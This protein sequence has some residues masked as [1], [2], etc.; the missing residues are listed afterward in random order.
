MKKTLL[1]IFIS[2]LTIA[3]EPWKITAWDVSQEQATRLAAGMFAYQSVPMAAE[4][5]WEGAA[6]DAKIYVSNGG[7]MAEFDIQNNQL[8]TSAGT[9]PLPENNGKIRVEIKEMDTTV[10]AGER[11]RQF[12]STNVSMQLKSNAALQAL[13]PEQQ[14]ILRNSGVLVLPKGDEKPAALRAIVFE[15]GLPPALSGIQETPENGQLIVAYNATEGFF[16]PSLWQSNYPNEK[17]SLTDHAMRFDHGKQGKESY[18]TVSLKDIAQYK[19]DNDTLFIN[20]WV[21]LVE[22]HGTDAVFNITANTGTPTKMALIALAPGKV[23]VGG[24]GT[25]PAPM[26]VKGRL[27][28]VTMKFSPVSDKLVVTVNGKEL[29]SLTLNI[30]ANKASISFGD[31]SSTTS[32]VAELQLFELYRIKE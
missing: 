16:S 12:R 6:G 31:G 7:L 21:R 26:I 28:H 29:K 24:Y 19:L 8:Q 20:A 18:Y 10:F 14:K 25:I 27:A 1:P 2:L 15:A 22:N 23:I 17:L 5:E 13:S 30:P 9:L 32:G 11:H 3:A 4:I